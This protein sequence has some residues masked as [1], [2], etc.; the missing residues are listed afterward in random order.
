MPGPPRM[1]GVRIVEYFTLEGRSGHRSGLLRKDGYRV[2]AVHSDGRWVSRNGAY[3]RYWT[4][5]GGDN[6]EPV[7]LTRE[8]A[9]K[10]AAIYGAVLE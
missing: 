4:G 1:R 7:P 6:Y 2:D 8:E 3:A 5:V 10:L 9:E